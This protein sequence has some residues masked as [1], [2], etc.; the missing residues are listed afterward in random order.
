MTE[1]TSYL[2]GKFVTLL[3]SEA[4]HLLRTQLGISY[5]RLLFLFVLQH[6]ESSTQHRL[7]QSLGYSDP[8]VS[9]MLRELVKD[10]Y[11]ATTPDPG[12][13]RKHLVRITPY[14]LELARQGRH[15]L[16]T[17]FDELM[18]IAEVDDQQL[19][20]ITHRLLAALAVKTQKDQS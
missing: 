8:A 9:T 6:Q 18:Q 12:H 4:E 10:G 2:L 15:L 13:G 11:V 19:Q 17:H 16:D 7:A 3:E 20:H 5:R 1:S 14:G